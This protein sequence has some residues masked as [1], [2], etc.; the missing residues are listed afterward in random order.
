MRDL[1]EYQHGLEKR[2]T[3]IKNIQARDIDKFEAHLA[4]HIIGLLSLALIRL[5]NGITSNL[6]GLGGLV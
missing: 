2:H 4:M 1:I 6:I 3:E 5:E